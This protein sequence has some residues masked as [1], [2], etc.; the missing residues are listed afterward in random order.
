MIFSGQRAVAT[1][2]A[3]QQ[4]SSHSAVRDYFIRA[5]PDNTDV[6][7]VGND[8]SND[9]SSAN[10]L[11]LKATDPPIRFRGKLSQLY[12]DVAVNGEKITWLAVSIE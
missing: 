12:V 6:I 7:Y 11:A 1:A 3:A 8:G 9:V 5:H 4:V 2:G 10:G